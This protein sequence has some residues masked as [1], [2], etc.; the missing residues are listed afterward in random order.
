MNMK[1]VKLIETIINE[2]KTIF[3]KISKARYVTVLRT[4]LN[5]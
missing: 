4:F 1:E 5:F 2:R 3:Y